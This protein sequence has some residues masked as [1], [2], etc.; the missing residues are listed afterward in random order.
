MKVLFS[1]AVSWKPGI[2]CG[3]ETVLTKHGPISFFAFALHGFYGA[4][5]FLWFRK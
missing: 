1:K 4:I 3:N 2:V 5:A